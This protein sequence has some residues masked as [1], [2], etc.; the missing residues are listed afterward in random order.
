[1][2]IFLS[3]VLLSATVGMPSFASEV[4]FKFDHDMHLQKV[5]KKNKID[6]MHC[7]N[8]SA[9]QNTKKIKLTLDAKKSFFKIPLKQICHECHQSELPQY[10]DA[11]KVCFTCHNSMEGL[12]KIKPSNHEN[13][14]WKT[15]HSAE[16]RTNGDYC[17]NCHMTSQCAK[18]HLHRDSIELSNHPKNFKYFHSVQARGQPQKCDTCHTKSFCVICHLGKK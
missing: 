2:R 9:D 16:A 3:Y 4:A 17:M 18:C 13:S 15:G 11:S 7:H 14:T 5:F 6:C 8:F 1:M 10:K 12:N